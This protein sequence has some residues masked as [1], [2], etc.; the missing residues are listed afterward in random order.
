MSKNKK[1]MPTGLL[2]GLALAFISF[3][4]VYSVTGD[5]TITVKYYVAKEDFAKGDVITNLKEQF[6]T[7][8]YPEGLTIEGAIKVGEMIQVTNEEGKSENMKPEEYLIGKKFYYPVR[9]GELEFLNKIDD[10]VPENEKSISSKIP[11]NMDLVSLKIDN[12]QSFGGKL[13]KDDFINLTF[14][15]TIESEETKIEKSITALQNLPVHS[16]IY[17]GVQAENSTPT[18]VAVLMTKKQVEMFNFY[19][20]TGEYI[21]TLSSG[22]PIE[23]ET[24]G[25]DINTIIQDDLLKEYFYHQLTSDALE[26]NKS[27]KEN[28][29]E[30]ESPSNDSSQQSDNQVVGFIK[31]DNKFY[32]LPTDANYQEIVNNYE[33]I[34]TFKSEEEAKNNAYSWYNA[35]K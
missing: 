34:F 31:G 17:D 20:S 4:G 11:E 23:Y 2:I 3:I 15:Y 32:V 5:D 30:T 35:N 28:F 13:K 12:L 19:K 26:D 9:E 27:N 25:I 18:G 16:L 10:R 6:D 7:K 29:E 1:G 8:D 21:I 24:D 14:Y 22:N 33:T